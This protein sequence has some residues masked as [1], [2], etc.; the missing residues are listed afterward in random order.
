M[1]LGI[2]TLARSFPVAAVQ[3][4]VALLGR[5]PQTAAA[6]LQGFSR[7]ALEGACYPAITRAADGDHVEG[8]LLKD[9]R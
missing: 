5:M 3:I 7:H 9:L 6:R 4:L 8:L 2:D 1:P